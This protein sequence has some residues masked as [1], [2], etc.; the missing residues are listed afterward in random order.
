[1]G[2]QNS[3]CFPCNNSLICCVRRET[4]QNSPWGHLL[5][6][7]AGE[8]LC[9]QFSSA[10]IKCIV[11]VCGV[12]LFLWSPRSTLSANRTAKFNS[13]C[14]FSVKGSAEWTAMRIHVTNR[15]TLVA[16]KIQCG[17]LCCPVCRL[18]SQSRGLSF[19]DT[20]YNCIKSY[21]YIRDHGTRPSTV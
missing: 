5:L 17:C 18:Y 15:R 2:A 12:Y 6:L 13:N 4:I 10:L 16:Q 11:F 3:L 1:M 9:H 19:N 21:N 20:T 14:M 7:V 8:C